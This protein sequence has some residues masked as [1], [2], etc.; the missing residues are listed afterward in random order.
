MPALTMSVIIITPLKSVLLNHFYIIKKDFNNHD[1]SFS[2]HCSTQFRKFPDSP[3]HGVHLMK[4]NVEMIQ[5]AAKELELPRSNSNFSNQLGTL[6]GLEGFYG[7]D[8]AGN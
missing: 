3:C 1:Y 2:P 5:N 6:L 7:I 8:L 4:S